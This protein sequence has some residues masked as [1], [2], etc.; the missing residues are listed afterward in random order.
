M[1]QM[2]I[3]AIVILWLAVVTLAVVVFALARQIG[4]LHERLRPAGAL[5]INRAVKAGEEARRLD[6]RTLNGEIVRIGGARD[7]AMLM[8]FVSPSCPICK[9][10][11]PTVK[12]SELAE[13]DWLDVVYASDG[14]NEDHQAF[15][16]RYGLDP[17]RYV[18]SE[19]LGQTFGVSKLPYAV[20]IDNNGRVASLGL[21]NSRE[22]LES[23][24]NAK[25][26]G[27]TSI[28]DYLQRNTGDGSTAIGA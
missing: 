3:A 9:V 26:S 11:L 16:R 14:D 4:I 12:T 20:L 17:S 6:V 10:L 24:F 28:Q 19:L 15:T 18:V 7:R 2:M 8:F 21:V 22:H 23:L 1:Q 27:V 13:A 25:E 5:T